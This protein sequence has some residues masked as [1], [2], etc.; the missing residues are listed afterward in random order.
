MLA[1]KPDIQPQ[2]LIIIIVL[3]ETLTD[4]EAYISLINSVWCLWIF[5]SCVL[6]YCLYIFLNLLN[7]SCHANISY[8]CLGCTWNTGSSKGAK[9]FLR[10][11]DY[12]NRWVFLLNV[13][14]R[15]SAGDP[16]LWPSTFPPNAATV[17]SV[18]FCVPSKRSYSTFCGLLRSLQTQL[19]YLL[20]PSTF[21]PNA[22]TVPF[23]AFY[24]PSKR[25]YSTFCGLL[26]S[27]QTQ[28]Q[29][30]KQPFVAFFTSFAIHSSII[31]SSLNTSWTFAA[32]L[33]DK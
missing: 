1:V 20:W 25:S 9:T 11:E 8:F 23:V 29:Y 6:H 31:L 2:W 30:L 16:L 21:P 17:P 24:I 5:S 13:L 3:L 27:L 32:L 33:N 18:A 26:H 22:A 15:S 28:L 7:N 19:Q 14:F 12:K 10:N 4:K